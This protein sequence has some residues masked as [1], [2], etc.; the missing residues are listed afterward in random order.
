MQYHPEDFAARTGLQ[1]ITHVCGTK[2]QQAPVLTELG[3]QA[4]DSGRC[5]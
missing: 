4:D 3:E 5:T 1:E 2:G